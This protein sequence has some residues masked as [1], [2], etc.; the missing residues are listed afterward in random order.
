[1][2]SQRERNSDGRKNRLYKQSISTLALSGSVFLLSNIAYTQEVGTGFSAFDG[3]IGTA[4]AIVKVVL[5]KRGSMIVVTT[6]FHNFTASH[7]AFVAVICPGKIQKAPSS[8]P[9]CPDQ[10]QPMRQPHNSLLVTGSTPGITVASP[11]EDSTYQPGNT[12]AVSVDVDPALQATEILMWPKISSGIPSLHLT[13]PPF[14]GN[15][16]L[17]H[18]VAGSYSLDFMVLDA[19]KNVI[20]GA[21]VLINVV[22]RDMPAELTPVV[23]SMHL[24]LPNNDTEG[25]RRLGVQGRY[26]NGTNR[27]LSDPQVGTSYT[28]TNTSIATVDANGVVMP[29]SDGITFIRIEHKGL[30][31]FTEVQVGDSAVWQKQ[32]LDHTAS[33]NI[34]TSDVRR[35]SKT[36]RLRQ[37]LVVTNN[38]P[39]PLSFPLMLVLSNLPDGIRL[40]NANGKTQAILPIGS[41]FLRLIT[42]SPW[43]LPPDSAAEVT[44]EFFDLEEVPITYTPRIFTAT[45]P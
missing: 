37:R 21:G 19:T 4:S 24:N 2:L 18:D 38:A 32:I 20:G 36:G 28:S 25:M 15:I 33:V 34:Q 16:V 17:P 39:L 42:A 23:Y 35:D 45:N 8:L 11:V 1:M 43:Y 12:V 3:S 31:T 22:P 5:P 27:D 44:L 14:S 29:L 13:G 10:E 40:T 30:Q 7:E 41:P 9:D 6:S 26:A